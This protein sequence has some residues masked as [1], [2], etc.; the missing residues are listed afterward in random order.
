MTPFL[1]VDGAQKLIEFVK[2]TFNAEDEE[3]MKGP[4]GRIA[5]AEF[6]IGDS[7]VMI[8]DSTTKYPPVA[9]QLYVYLEDV[10]KAYLR[11]LDAGGISLQEPSDQFYGDRN[12][13]VKDP[14][15]NS[16]WIATRVEEVSPD[17]LQRRMKARSTQ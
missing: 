13:G 7:V 8:A 11:A 2:R 9:S 1:I 10:D 3:T 14:T 12:A 15:G 5:H 17:E 6:R 16:W 4:D